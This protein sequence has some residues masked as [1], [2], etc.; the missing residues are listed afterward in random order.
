MKRHPQELKDQIIQEVKQVGNVSAVAKKHD[1]SLTTVHSWIRKQA[2]Q[3]EDD[4]IKKNKRL[5]K[6]LAD[7]ELE[8]QILKELLKK[9]NLA[10]LGD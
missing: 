3:P 5:E 6:A 4:L 10:W 1:I 2:R 9:T 8:N 7:K